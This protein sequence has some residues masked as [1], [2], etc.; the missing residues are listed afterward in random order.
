MPSAT[1]LSEE[2]KEEYLAEEV[3]RQPRKERLQEVLARVDTRPQA[4]ELPQEWND[5]K[6]GDC[7]HDDIDGS[8]NGVYVYVC[9][10]HV[11]SQ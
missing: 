1:E 5:A 4:P 3:E 8:G 10:P 2:D 6:N 7:Q 9:E 11:I